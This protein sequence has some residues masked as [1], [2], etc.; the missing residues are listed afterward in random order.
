M[1][2]MSHL[3]VR[4]HF[5]MVSH[6]NKWATRRVLDQCSKL[7]STNINSVFIPSDQHALLRDIKLPCGSI[8]NTICHLFAA[9]QL[10]QQRYTEQPMSEELSALWSNAANDAQWSDFFAKRMD[11]DFIDRLPNVSN[12]M[13]FNNFM[14]LRSAVDDNSTNWQHIVQGTPD[15]A[16]FEEVKY[17]TTDGEESK[18]QRSFILHHAFNH[19]TH[20]RGQISSALVQFGGQPPQLDMTAFYPVWKEIHSKAFKWS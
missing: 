4:T 5:V 10:W 14:S 12:T 8:Y 9:D 18:L 15:S 6:Y 2:H 17:R 3:S 1:N 7:I 16:F 19:A 20:H 11:L 13:I